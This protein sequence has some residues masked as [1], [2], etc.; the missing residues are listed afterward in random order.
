MTQKAICSTETDQGCHPQTIPP[1][2]ITS[3][4]FTPRNVVAAVRQTGEAVRLCANDWPSAK[5]LNWG[6]KNPLFKDLKRL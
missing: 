4:I 3:R 6:V 1:A 2:A 5:H